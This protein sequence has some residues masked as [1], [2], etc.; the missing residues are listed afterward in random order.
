MASSSVLLNKLFMM[1]ALRCKIVVLLVQEV[2][3]SKLGLRFEESEEK[4]R[5][6]SNKSPKNGPRTGV[7]DAAL[8]PWL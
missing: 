7:L 6:V 1:R 4:T 8:M 2:S 5:L 3:V